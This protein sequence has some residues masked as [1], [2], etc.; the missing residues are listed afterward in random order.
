MIE[1]ENGIPKGYL[2]KRKNANLLYIYSIY[3]FCIFNIFFKVNILTIPNDLRIILNS[4]LIILSGS[5]LCNY[6]MSRRE[7]KEIKMYNHNNISAF[8]KSEKVLYITPIVILSI[9]IPL[10]MVLYILIIGSIYL[11]VNRSLE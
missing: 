11:A 6:I 2:Q 7:Y 10:I 1:Y 8:T 5:F 3:L 9:F 4:I